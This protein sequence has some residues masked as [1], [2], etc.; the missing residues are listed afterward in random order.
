MDLLWL[1]VAALRWFALAFGLLMVVATVLSET[2]LPHW[3]VRM[4]D[5]PRSQILVIC[6]G[7]AILYPFLAWHGGMGWFDWALPVVLLLSAGRQA[8]WIWPYVGAGK[9]DLLRS[10]EEPDADSVIRVLISNVLQQNEDYDLWRSVIEQ[11]DFDL[12]ACAETNER[13]I[14]E[15]GKLLDASHPHQK[16]VPQDNMYGMAVWS[17]LELQDVTVERIVQ[18]DIPSMHLT[19]KLP[20]GQPIRLHV[21]HPRPPAP[22][23]GDSSAPRDAELTVMAR[24]IERACDEGGG[25]DDA[26][27]TIVCGDMND[28]AW[29]RTSDIFLAISGLLDPRR[30]RGLFNTFHAGHWWVRFPLDHFFVDRRFKLVEMRRLDY[31]GSD[32]FPVYLAVSLE[33]EAEQEQPRH[34][35]TQ[36][37]REQAGD[38]IEQQKDREADGDEN[39]HLRNDASPEAQADEQREA[40]SDPEGER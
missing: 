38:L 29:S 35:V 19:V 8:M 22:Q 17:R 24:R 23:E 3:P 11:E 40:K 37:D 27:P 4:W 15:I 1:T 14:K 32:H 30:G 25:G 9:K 16:F 39:G 18:E 12:I 2:D 36:D 21:L 20:N 13:W 28:V 26:L 34:K 33:P 6:F 10:D 7:I 31:V 5:F